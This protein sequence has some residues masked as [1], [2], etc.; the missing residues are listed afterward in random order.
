MNENQFLTDI[1]S[2]YQ[3]LLNNAEISEKI[4]T[5]KNLIVKQNKN[6]NK[7]MF[8]GNG[9]SAAIASHGALDF[10]KQA[11]IRSICF[12]D[13]SFITAFANDYGYE[14][15]VE[16]ALSFHGK[17][18]DIAILISSSGNS[19]NMVNAARTAKHLGINVITFTGF[20]AENSLKQE[21]ILNFWVNSRA[22]NIVENTHQM[23]LLMVCD[24]IV[25][26]AEYSA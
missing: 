25:G 20:R 17:S 15:W 10:T 13:S 22:Y 1:L 5:A 18:G 3:S 11:G 7:V 8:A 21:G 19:L 14:H 6:G 12:N 9:A 26:K 24:L 16:K 4:I 2:Q 23:W